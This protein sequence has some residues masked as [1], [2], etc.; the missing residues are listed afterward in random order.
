MQRKY[1]WKPD[2]A[3]HRDKHFP[4]PL[5][6]EAL[7]EHVDLRPFCSPIVNQGME[8][9]CTANAG[10][11]GAFEFLELRALKNA[12]QDAVEFDPKHFVRGSRQFNYY[13]TR[14]LHGWQGTDSGAFLRDV[15]KV[16]N[17][18]GCCREATWPYDTSKL[19]V[20]P[21]QAAYDEAA[22]HKISEYIRI[23]SIYSLRKCLADGFP[24]IFG[25]TVYESFESPEVARTGL[26]PLPAPGEKVLGGHAVCAVGYDDVK[27]VLIVRNSWGESWGDKG[28]FY[29]PYSFI[30][31]D[32]SDFWTL[33]K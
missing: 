2:P 15:V 5:T 33:R 22:N 18:T 32:A 9:S 27:K 16:L 14:A 1:N 11:S 24:C 25:F 8:G 7:P 13:A 26:M 17:K 6:L 29:M 23:G 31:S 12:G 20:Q 28:Y 3:D 4:I 10:V 30:V 19:A 21:N